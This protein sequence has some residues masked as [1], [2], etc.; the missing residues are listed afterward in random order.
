MSLPKVFITREI[1]PEA[2]EKI[3][4][5]AD[6][7][8]WPDELPPPH[9]VLLAKAHDSDGLLTML[10]DRIDAGLLQKSP[11]LKVV[12]NLAVGYDNIDIPEATKRHIY[13]GYTPGVLTETTADLI[14]ALM[15]AA[16]ISHPEQQ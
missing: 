2:L 14:F 7:E 9:E 11:R 3:A 8:V 1:F 6:L 16:A 13:V 4:S 10:N 12:S 5:A 15:M